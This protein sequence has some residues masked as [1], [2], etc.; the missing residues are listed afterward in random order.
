[1]NGCDTTSYLYGIGKVT[2]LKALNS[3]ATLKLLGEEDVTMAEVVSDATSFISDV[4]WKHVRDALC[5]LVKENDKHENI[6]C[7]KAKI[8]CTHFRGLH[9]A[10]LS[11]PL[12]DL[13]WKSSLA[14]E[15]PVAANPVQYR[16]TETEDKKLLPVAL[17]DVSPA[18][19]EVLQ[20]IKCG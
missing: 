17:P 14:S 13:I 16:W 5:C 9:A 11:R 8:S 20:M 18:P 6:Q 12:S 4:L 10:R 15:P 19:A 7:A 2:T 3:G 1:M